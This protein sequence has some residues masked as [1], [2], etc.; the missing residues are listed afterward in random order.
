MPSGG[1]LWIYS[2]DLTHVLPPF[3]A[4]DNSTHG[5]LWTPI[6][7][8][9]EIVL[10]VTLPTAARKAL[11]LELES[12]NVGYRGFGAS[13]LSGACNVDVICPEGDAW[14]AEIASV[15]AISTGGSLFCTGFMVNN[16]AL[17]RR[18][19]F[20]TARHCG[21][22]A[23]N[24]ASLVVYWN[25]EAST[26]A[27]P[28]DGSLDQFQTGSFFRASY[29]PSDFT[30]VELDEDPDPSWGVTFAGWDRSGSDATSAVAVHHPDSD[31]KA[32]SFEYQPTS[33]TSY[34]GSS[35]PGD[36]THVRVADWDLG[37]TEPG[38]SGSPLF[39]A[40]HR[41]IGQLHGGFA[42]CGNNSSDWYGKLSVSWGGGGTAATRLSDWLDPAGTGAVALDILGGAPCDR[43]E[44]CEPGVGESA[45]SCP[46]DCGPPPPDESGA[47]CL[48][49]LDNDCDGPADCDDDAC[50]NGAAP[51]VDGDGASGCQ[52]CD[53]G[54]L[55]VW[56]TPDEVLGLLAGPDGS[57]SWD[58]P[59]NPGAV[60]W[61]Y[62]L[63]RSADP[64]DF[65]AADCVASDVTDPT[66]VD[67]TTPP[68][69]ALSSYL[70]RA[71]NGCPV[72]GVGPL[73]NTS[74]GAPRTAAACP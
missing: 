55:A 47:A 54:N 32:I 69:D 38:S 34:L 39:D 3:D 72:E 7:P 66:A 67:P 74:S 59:T 15:A 10:E 73:G 22:G 49:G 19:Y 11:V 63:L 24:A 60:A 31:E 21:I 42:A 6:V 46:A 56:A 18:P 40:Q 29:S 9:D 62:D 8:A 20:M 44:V 41:V 65:L 52:D 35:S 25:Y 70:V 50:A 43:D 2:A 68:A 64:S 37:T 27:G 48:D 5:E 30:L 26:C 61:T 58:V 4:G 17:D 53:D 23:A 1:R 12:I 28:R 36:G 14:R 45:C 57:L 51:D 16:T 71:V 13:L 33:T